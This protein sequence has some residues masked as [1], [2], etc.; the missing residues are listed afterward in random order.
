MTTQPGPSTPRL[1]L[2]GLLTSVLAVAFESVAVATAMPRAGQELGRINLYAWVFTMFVLGMVIATAISGRVVDR[3]GPVGPLL[4]GQALF[5]VGLL[6]AGSAWSMPALIVAR[7]GQGVGGGTFN[8]A[9]M[10]VVARAYPPLGRAR[11]MTWVSVCWTF[12]AFVGPFVAGWITDRLSWHWVFWS[13]VPVMVAAMA[14]VAPALRRM[15]LDDVPADASPSET[16]VEE[17]PP[18]PVWAAL[19]T[20]VGVAGVQYAG[21]VRGAE[22]VAVGVAAAVALVA[23]VPRLMPAGFLTLGRGLVAVVW[24]RLLFAGGFFA[25]EAFLP[26]ML[27]EQRRMSLTRAGLALTVGAVGWMTGSWLQSRTWLAWRRDLMVTLGVCHLAVGLALVTVFARFPGLPLVIPAL[28]WILAGLGMG[29]ATASSALAV[30]TLSP[31]R[32]LGR[33]SSSLQVGDGLGTSLLG[34]LAGVVFAVLHPRAPAPHTF[35]AVFGVGLV[36]ALLGV[37]ASRRIGRVPH[38]ASADAEVPEPAPLREA[39][40]RPEA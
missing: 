20:G 13:V 32:S 14:I 31:V 22:G 8:L 9:F 19:L 38:E 3:I 33:N 40:A 4:A 27:V 35:G 34:G 11:I 15:R 7:F 21:T 10:V 25:S 28:G 17:P 6:A 12:P 1:L 2:V 23:G 5:I 26:L 36:A 29:L 37:L 30:M 24:A 39:P 16:G 18:V